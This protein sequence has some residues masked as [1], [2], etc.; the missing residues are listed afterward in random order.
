MGHDGPVFCV[1]V[2]NNIV[3]TGSEDKTVQPSTYLTSKSG[4]HQ[5]FVLCA[6]RSEFGI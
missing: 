1:A 6:C 3:V 2:R 4:R 5:R